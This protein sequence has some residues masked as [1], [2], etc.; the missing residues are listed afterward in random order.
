MGLAAYQPGGAGRVGDT[1]Q[2]EPIHD[3]AEIDHPVAA[4]M[5]T[6]HRPGLTELRDEGAHRSARTSY[7]GGDHFDGHFRLGR[8][9]CDKGTAAIDDERGLESRVLREL[10]EQ[11]VGPR[12]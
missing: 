6:L 8:D 10:P 1:H 11:I 12:G 4:E 2:N 9:A 7:E 3:L 5:D